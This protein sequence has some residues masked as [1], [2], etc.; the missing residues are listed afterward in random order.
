MARQA[1]LI[2]DSKSARI[3]LSR[4]LKKSGFENVTMAESGEQA[5]EQ[6]E[7]ITPDAI[8]VDYFMDGMDGLETIAAIKKIPRLTNIPVVMCT[9]NEGKR[10]AEAAESHGAVGIMTKPPTREGLQEIIE[11]VD[12]ATEAVPVVDAT[13]VVEPVRDLPRDSE[14]VHGSFAISA[15]EVRSIARRATRQIAQEVVGDLAAQA[16]ERSLKE[17]PLDVNIDKLRDEIIEQVNRDVEAIVIKLNDRVVAEVIGTHFREQ[18]AVFSEQIAAQ[19]EVFKRGVTSQLP[20]REQLLEDVLRQV[21]DKGEMIEEIRSVAEGSIDAHAAE[22]A[23]RVAREVAKNTAAEVAE[24][25]FEQ[26]F[27]TMPVSAVAVAAG[28]SGR[29][30]LL[31]VGGGLFLVGL[32]AGFLL[33]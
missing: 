7:T 2:D 24:E 32:I 3:V 19:L 30:R 27:K 21:P 17:R 26:R 14:R 5:L 29:R 18:W 8:F 22:T 20:G 1:L 6:L 10:Y 28:G 15:E 13:P 4:L 11:L 9:A 33:L 16:V 23:T 12:Q 25:L 31:M